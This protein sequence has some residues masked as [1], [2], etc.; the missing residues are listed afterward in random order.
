MNNIRNTAS[1]LV[2]L[3]LV[4]AAAAP[5]V[6]SVGRQKTRQSAAPPLSAVSLSI[7][8]EVKRPLKLTAADISK[9]PRRTVRAS[10]HGTEAT[11]EGVP[12]FEVL[13]LAGLEFGET[14]RGKR[15]ETYLIVEAADGYKAVFALPELDPAFTDKVVLLAD[16]RDGKPLAGEE[17]RLRIV[18]PD[19]RR[20]ARW[21][22]QVVSLVVRR[23]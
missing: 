4:I 2:A 11:F 12:L 16:K 15:L 17:G 18:V 22:R 8:G 23:A 6:T 7:S 1:A 19:E 21:V 13:K 5:G 9:L 14:L 20:H 10:D 3:S